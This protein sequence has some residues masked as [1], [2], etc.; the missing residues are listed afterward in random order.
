MGANKTSDPNQNF[1]KKSEHFD[2][3]SIMHARDI[4]L[5]LFSR[6]II[7]ISRIEAVD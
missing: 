5:R 2:I 3:L 1:K 7:A 6:T 4:F